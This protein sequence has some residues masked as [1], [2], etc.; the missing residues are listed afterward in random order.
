MKRLYLISIVLLNLVFSAWSPPTL[1]W[2]DTSNFV[3]RFTLQEFGAFSRS[4]DWILYTWTGSP[5]GFFNF[6]ADF[7]VEQACSTNGQGGVFLSEGEGFGYLGNI[8]PWPFPLGTTVNG[9]DLCDEN[10]DLAAWFFYGD[11]PNLIFPRTDGVLWKNPQKCS[12]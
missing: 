3:Q 12:F 11:S 2:H 5:F 4:G 10:A 8:S 1:A 7:F 9:I 6:G